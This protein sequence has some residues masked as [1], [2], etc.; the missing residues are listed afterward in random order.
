MRDGLTTRLNRREG[1]SLTKANKVTI[2]LYLER[3]DLGEDLT[4]ELWE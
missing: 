1:L 3:D 4:G 2:E